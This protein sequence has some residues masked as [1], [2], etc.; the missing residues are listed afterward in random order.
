MKKFQK[1]KSWTAFVFGGS[2]LTSTILSACVNNSGFDF[3][4]IRSIKVILP[5]DTRPTGGPQY[6]TFVEITKKYNDWFNAN[7]KD[8][9]LKGYM[10]VET[11]PIKGFSLNEKT[12]TTNLAANDFASLPNLTF[13]FGST[14]YE[15]AKKKLEMNFNIIPNV[16]KA[17][18]SAFIESSR[19][20]SQLSPNGLYLLPMGISTNILYINKA[21]LNYLLTEAL[22]ETNFTIKQ[23]DVE[24]FK[25]TFG[26]EKI[27]DESTSSTT[28]STDNK[29]IK[30]YTPL[31]QR[32]E[33][34]KKIFNKI[35]DSY[36]TKAENKYEL[37]RTVFENWTDFFKFTTILADAFKGSTNNS[38]NF[39]GTAEIGSLF[40]TMAF[41]KNDT[42]YT[43]FLWTR[44][45]D[46][47]YDY[48]FLKDI[49]SFGSQTLKTVYDLMYKLSQKGGVWIHP[50]IDLAFPSANFIEN[51]LPFILASSSAYSYQFSKSSQTSASEDDVLAIIPPTKWN[52]SDK[53]ASF[54]TSGG[55]L[56]GI[57][58]NDRIDKG[59]NLFVDWLVNQDKE[60]NNIFEYTK[61]QASVKVS[62]SDYYALKASYVPGSNNFV[63]NSKNIKLI[64]DPAAKAAFEVFS[65]SASNSKNQT[66]S[67]GINLFKNTNPFSEPVGELSRI[68]RNYSD[69]AFKGQKNIL[70]YEQYFNNLKKNPEI[71]GWISRN[72]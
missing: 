20:I 40:E 19:N 33:A 54:N 53:N 51:K 63:N 8:L 16:K 31:A 30:I 48:S 23:E 57:K 10:P 42:D 1:K 27:T 6:P 61:N 14:V 45:N 9:S 67:Y 34:V 47:K 4:S 18:N 12:I 69:N 58:F 24:W 35:S 39:F 44:K 25:Q 46:G 37:S 72:L 32:T 13:G 29:T 2:L 64:A 36:F 17:Y 55:A 11:V 22:K 66:F 60:K 3:S 52:A 70:A 65:K 21:V 71:E 5:F 56:L 7:K 68:F 62:G 59:T 41:V 49:N 50:Q 26:V 43:K 15:I 38:K 28:N